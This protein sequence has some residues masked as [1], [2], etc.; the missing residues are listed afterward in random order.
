[1]IKGQGIIISTL[2]LL[3]S[4]HSGHGFTLLPARRAPYCR[5]VGR[6]MVKAAAGGE[7][8]SSTHRKQQELMMEEMSRIGAQK[9]ASLGIPERAKRAMLAEAVEDR[10][11]DLTDQLEQ[12]IED[13]TIPE[14]NRPQAVQ[15]AQQTKVLQIQYQEL[16]S[17]KSS[18]ILDSLEAA[19]KADDETDE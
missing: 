5:S 10:I 19:M 9:I 2:L 16:V 11:F 1:M 14:E 12:L 18:S 3:Q 15:L 8:D 17:G 4:L 7:G 6:T 13:N